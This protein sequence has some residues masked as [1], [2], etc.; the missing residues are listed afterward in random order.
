[1]KNR[2]A[3][4]IRHESGIGGGEEEIVMYERISSV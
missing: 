3:A 2:K 4:I 1:M